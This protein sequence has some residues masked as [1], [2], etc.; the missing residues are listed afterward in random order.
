MA[1]IADLCPQCR[2]ITRCHVVERGGIAGGVVLG[3]PLIL[4]LSSVCCA[5]GEC[6]LEF[7]S[8]FWDQARTVLPAE[9]AALDLGAL[10]AC[11]NPLLK[12]KVALTDLQANP[13]LG[14]AFA[15]LEQLLAGGLRTALKDALL[16]WPSFDQ[17]RQD[18]FLAEV[19]DCSRALAF[20]RSMAGR[21]TLG[22][23][24]CLA[25]VLG[26]V[27]VWLGCFL[28]L[29]G[30]LKLLGWAGVTGGGLLAGG[31]LFTLFEGNRGGRWVRGVLLPEV[32]RSGIRPAALLAVLEGTG[33][34]SQVEDEL[35]LLRPLA[36][37]LRAELAS[38]G[39]CGDAKVFGF[40]VM[41]EGSPTRGGK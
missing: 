15:L 7:R 35:R 2:R 13:R 19:D 38:S 18:R 27:G 12:E 1:L 23:V 26:C 41:P 31:L 10:L 8:E 6:G 36:P 5:C 25:G 39:T 37:A 32:R 16:R 4:P 34:P 33:S 21:Y 29:G 30:G 20:A 22:A 11:T 28:V 3:L 24:G 40:G 9:A 17:G 14:G